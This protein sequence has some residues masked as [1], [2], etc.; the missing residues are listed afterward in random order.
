M[1]TKRNYPEKN[2]KVE[3][4]LH[5]LLSFR[6]LNIS[7]FNSVFFFLCCDVVIIRYSN[8]LFFQNTSGLLELGST[9]LQLSFESH[10]PATIPSAH[11]DEVKFQG[12]KYNIYAQSYLCFGATEFIK[13]Y[14]A[15]VIK[16][17]FYFRQ[18]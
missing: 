6:Y 15:F 7:C 4:I 17:R 13:K 2:L 11:K 8:K 1:L 3:E 18:A 14:R 16:V 5:H 10:T 9:S 12:K